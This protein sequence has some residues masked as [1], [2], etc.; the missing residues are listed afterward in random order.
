MSSDTEPVCLEREAPVTIKKQRTATASVAAVT[1]SKRPRSNATIHTPAHTLNEKVIV[2]IGC[3][4]PGLPH[5]PFFSIDI[6]VSEDNAK[7]IEAFSHPTLSE[8]MKRIEELIFQRQ[9]EFPHNIIENGVLDI[10]SDA[11]AYRIK[12]VLTWFYKRPE[13]MDAL[14]TIDS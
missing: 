13:C 3:A 2:I 1:S 9:S 11:S 14:R 12:A 5:A 10:I 8:S 7:Y 6:P 4:L